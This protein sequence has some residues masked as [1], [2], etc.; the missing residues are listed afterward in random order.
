MVI[1]H[2]IKNLVT[3][4]GG[5]I[6]MYSF[7]NWTASLFKRLFKDGKNVKEEE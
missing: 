2:L 7:G 6:S 1:D 4:V 5:I 3:L